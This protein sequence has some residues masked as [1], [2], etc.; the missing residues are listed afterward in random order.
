MDGEEG[1]F[2][3]CLRGNDRHDPAGLAG[4]PES[5]S[6][7]ADV[8]ARREKPDA[9]QHIGCEGGKIGF[10]LPFKVISCGADG[11]DGVHKTRFPHMAMTPNPAVRRRSSEN[12]ANLLSAIMGGPWGAIKAE[13]LPKWLMREDVLMLPAGEVKLRPGGQKAETGF[14]EAHTP[15]A[16]EHGVQHRLQPV[17]VGDIVGGIGKLLLG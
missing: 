8:G 14:G 9:R 5:D 15:F 16:F 1:D 2:P 7:G 4:A 13:P 17:Q 6:I 11:H 3:G 10:L 12:H